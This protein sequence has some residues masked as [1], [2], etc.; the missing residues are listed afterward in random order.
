ML[1]HLGIEVS[2]EEVEQMFNDADA[3][4]GGTYSMKSNCTFAEYSNWTPFWQ[5]ASIWPNLKR[6]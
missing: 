5:V 1:T 4:S 2:E 3:D 6:L